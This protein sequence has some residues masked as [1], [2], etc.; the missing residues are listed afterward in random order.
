MPGSSHVGTHLQTKK[1]PTTVHWGLVTRISFVAEIA[2]AS[3]V[4]EARILQHHDSK[5]V[6]R[7]L[8]II[9]TACVRAS[10]HDIVSLATTRVKVAPCKDCHVH[11]PRLHR[12]TTQ[13]MTHPTN[14]TP[15]GGLNPSQGLNARARRVAPTRSPTVYRLHTTVCSIRT[16]NS[17][18]STW[19]LAR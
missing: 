9:P 17:T 15:S 16:N 11:V 3:G 1:V 5:V 2:V 7:V 19:D 6:H 12:L 8:T 4:L 13:S 14:H 10:E 18:T